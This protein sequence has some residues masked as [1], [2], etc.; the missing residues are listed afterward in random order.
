MRPPSSGDPTAEDFVDPIAIVDPS[1]SSS[2]DVSQYVGHCHDR[3]GGAWTDFGGC[4]HV[5]S[6][7][8][9]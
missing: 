2:S 7:F 3:S 9:C 5:A 1:S 6:G 8:T 4:A